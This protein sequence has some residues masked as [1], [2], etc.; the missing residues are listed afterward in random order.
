MK[1]YYNWAKL[2]SFELKNTN[3][4]DIKNKKHGPW[5]CNKMI[6]IQKFYSVHFGP[7]PSIFSFSV[8]FGSISSTLVL[9]V[10]SI[11][12]APIISTPILFGPHWLYPIH[13]VHRFY[14]VHI[15]P[16]R[17]ILSTFVLFNWYWSYSV[18]Y[19]PIQSYL[20]LFVT[21]VDFGPNLCIL[22]YL[23]NFSPTWS[24]FPFGSIL[25]IWSTL[26][27]LCLLQSI[28]ML[29]HIRKRYVSIGT[30]N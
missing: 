21:Y 9:L 20:L 24:S 5:K 15:G 12:I 17:S 6:N 30:L 4:I 29:L 28:F 18:H 23:V 3:K 14:L 2:F 27:H 7:I 13:S 1:F 25:S 16:I 11:H 19:V 22:S 26:F 10:H 8:H